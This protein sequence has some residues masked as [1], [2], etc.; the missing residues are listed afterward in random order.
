MLGCY[1]RM[2]CSDVCCVFFRN[3][4][5]RIVEHEGLARPP[6]E[7]YMLFLLKSICIWK[8][9]NGFFTYWKTN[10]NTVRSE[11]SR[12]ICNRYQYAR[13]KSPDGCT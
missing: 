8:I 7:P 4:H 10:R 5:T 13:E 1:A 3:D 12:R 2:L 6:F 11:H 9:A